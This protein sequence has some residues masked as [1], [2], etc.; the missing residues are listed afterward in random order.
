MNDEIVLAGRSG[1]QLMEL[2]RQMGWSLNETE[3]KVIASHFLKLKRNPSRIELESLAQTWSEHCKH[4]VFTGEITLV[5]N[6]KKRVIRNLFKSTIKKA[7]LGIAKKKKFLWSVFWDNAGIIEFTKDFGVAF[8]VETHNHPSALD[9]YAGAN[10]GVG[11]VV[12]DIL[13]CGLGAKPIASTDVFCFADPRTDASLVPSGILH[14]KRV[15]KGVR[16]GV[17][18]YGNPMGIPTVNGSIFFDE[19]FLGN[20]LVFCGTVGLI[21]RGAEKKRPRKGDSIVVIGGR[22]GRDGIHGA[23][24]SS[25]ELSEVSETSVVQIGNPIEEK[26]VLD[27][28]LQAR[29]RRLFN[30]ITDFGAG[31]FGS[32]V[33]EM[34]QGLGA[35]VFLDRAPLK[36][37]GLLPWEIW[38]SESQERM[39]LSVS[40]AHL[41]AFRELC[42]FEDVE[43]FELGTFTGSGKIE[44]FYGTETVGVLDLR[45]LHEGLPLFCERAEWSAPVFFIPSFSQPAGL[46][47]VLRQL[48]A[49]PNIASKESTV[50][51]YDF[52]VQGG[53][54]GKPFVG[55]LGDGPADAAVIKPLPD[56]PL[57]ITLSNGINPWYSDLDPYWMAASVIDESIRNSLSVGGNIDH[58]ALLDNFC[59]GNPTDPRKLGA[60]VRT[61]QGCHDTAQAFGTPFISGKDSFYNE[62][63]IGEKTISVP[64]TLLISA[65]SVM[66]DASALLSMDFKEA[67]NPVYLV[68]STFN[69]LGGSHYLHVLGKT[70]GMPPLVRFAQAKK[71]FE[72]V[73]RLTR[74]NVRFAP[75][76]VRAIHDLSEG[77][78]AVAAAEMAFASPYGVELDL[79]FV[80]LGEKKMRADEVLFS[81]SNSRFL[82]E[83]Q[84]E[85]E[86]AFRRLLKGVPFARVGTVTPE[87]FLRV[88]G[89]RGELLLDSSCPVLKAAWTRTLD[90]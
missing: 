52:E 10:T 31:G 48:L 58:L 9:P 39:V 84:A 89:A 68:G 14:P 21:P 18:E 64:G 46:N 62:F 81:E 2:S 22:T 71:I 5:E 27:V 23:T 45:F 30:A 34:A 86:N 16:R 36:Q 32:A 3:M 25:A 65:V 80:P 85:H 79:S 8:K 73:S 4:K 15:F 75:R 67:G 38:V 53:T 12:R 35:R 55:R 7:T 26:K 49:H 29:D 63:R 37:Q 87:P 69:E 78:L 90:W 66:P 42:A 33:G 17:K 88:R 40:P 51:Q 54:I 6:G 56:R 61:A 19:R 44:L 11:G 77:G 70:G 50:R 41:K 1:H 47:A 82:I 24:F 28:I 60:L 57:A 59:W 76:M 20:P 83:V 43:A 72:S 74:Q 13:G